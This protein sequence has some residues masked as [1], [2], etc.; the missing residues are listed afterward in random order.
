V[1]KQDAAPA[2][3][4]PGDEVARHQRKE[5]AS[6]GPHFVTGESIGTREWDCHSLLD[7][8]AAGG[9]TAGASCTRISS[10]ANQ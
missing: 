2:T 4:A 7:G 5:N 8:A 6:P 9:R 10:P 3:L 1:T